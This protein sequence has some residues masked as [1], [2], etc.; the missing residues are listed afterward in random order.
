MNGALKCDE[1]DYYAKTIKNRYKAE[2]ESVDATKLLRRTLAQ[3][4]EKVTF[5]G[6]GPLKNASD[7][8]KKFAGR[9]NRL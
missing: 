8:L 2:V 6:I 7:L 1:V 9:N 4:A 3:S 5:V